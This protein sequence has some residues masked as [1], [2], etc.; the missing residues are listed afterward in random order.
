MAKAKVKRTRTCA[1]CQ[2]T[3]V[4]PDSMIK[5]RFKFGGCRAD[6]GLLAN[7]FIQTEKGWKYQ[8]QRGQDGI[9]YVGL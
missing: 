2:R 9:R 3:F 4:N 7:G 5:H 1:E 8:H 6:E